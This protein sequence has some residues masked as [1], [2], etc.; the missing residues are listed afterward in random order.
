MYFLFLSLYRAST[1]AEAEEK[2][3]AFLHRLPV[4]VGIAK[5]VIHDSQLLFNS[6]NQLFFLFLFFFL[7]A[8]A[9]PVQMY[10]INGLQKICDI[11]L[12]NPSWSIAHLVAH[13]NLTDHLNHPKV[14][15]LIDFPDHETYM[16]PLQ[17]RLLSHLFL[18]EKICG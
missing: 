18:S 4:F 17:V 2:F 3:N 11:L 9:V 5:E 16:T 12:E 14:Q 13:F 15:D 10:N 7:S 8:A 6:F 1:Q